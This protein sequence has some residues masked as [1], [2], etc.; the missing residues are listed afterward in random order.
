MREVVYSPHYD[1]YISKVRRTSDYDMKT[2]HLHRKYEI[3]YL[4]EGMRRYFI[5]DS[6]YLVNA[7]NIVL[8]DKD[9]IHKTGPVDRLPHTRYVLNFNPEYISSAWGEENVTALLSF[10]GQGVR[11]LTVS[12]KTQNYVENLLQK[13][14]DRNGDSSLQG[15]LMRKS[16]LTELLLCLDECVAKQLQ[17]L[18]EE[19]QKIRNDTVNKISAYISENF[20]EPLS[21]AK[22][23]AQFYISPCYL[24][25][26][27]KKSTGLSIVEYL[28]SV[29][30]RAAKSYLET[31]DLKV[32]EITEKV[33]FCTSSHFSRVFKS[34]T[35]F[36]PNLYRKYYREES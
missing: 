5:D 4:S 20:R 24:S 12:M 2:F 9:Q 31:T 33:G 15:D 32:T 28:N 27:F 30:I 22:I 1:F 13:M 7:G 16:L 29:R 36:S 8:I 21:L 14:V 17:S 26:L 10:F 3:Y 34:G 11:V 25:H 19:P 35:G 18:R 6:A 23:A